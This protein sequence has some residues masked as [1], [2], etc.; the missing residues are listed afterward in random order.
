MFTVMR[1][2][3]FGDILPNT[4][5]AKIGGTALLRG[6]E[7]FMLHIK[8]HPLMWMSLFFVWVSFSKTREW[9]TLIMICSGYLIY[10]ILIGGD[11]KPTSRFILPLTGIFAAAV[12]MLH[13]KIKEL[14]Q[15]WK[16]AT[17]CQKCPMG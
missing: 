11:F 9:F 16:N 14:G 10:V 5:Y 15:Y 1:L 3:Y 13:H 12:S 8:H 7:Y 17:V 4:F 6:F 2:I